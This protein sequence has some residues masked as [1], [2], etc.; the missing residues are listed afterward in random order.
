[1]KFAEID[2]FG[3]Y[4]APISVMMVAAWLATIALRQLASRLGVALEL[5][6]AL[7]AFAQGNSA[8]A[9]AW[10]RYLDGRLATPPRGA[11]PT[12]AALRARSRI[13]VVAEAL[14]RH[15]AY[16]DAGATA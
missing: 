3:V 6:T 7:A 13:L 1:M 8:T 5:D 14:F 10:L 15:A 9:I 16:F 12:V 2:L 11:P 4:V